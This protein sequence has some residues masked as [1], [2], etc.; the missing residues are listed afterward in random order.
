MHIKI[1]SVADR[2]RS[3]I[4]NKNKLKNL[5]KFAQNEGMLLHS[6]PLKDGTTAKIL[7]NAIEYD[8]LIM[9]NG[10]VLT[11]RGQSG[12]TEDVAT[13][14]LGL[15]EHINRRR[16]AVEDVNIDT[17]SFILIDEYLKKY[18]NLMPEI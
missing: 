3:G 2:I 9:K 16:R 14:I 17:E 6:I 7:A 13:G 15:F 4:I 12:Q 5:Q 8:C 18:G 11:A 10:K 1:N